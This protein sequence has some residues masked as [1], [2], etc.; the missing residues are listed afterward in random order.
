[1]TVATVAVPVSVKETMSARIVAWKD[2]YKGERCFCVGNGP[3]LKDTPLH[4]LENEYSFGLNKISDIYDKTP[5]RPSFYVNVTVLT[6]GAEWAQ[7]AK[8]SMVQTPSFID[9]G[10]LPYVLEAT[11]GEF[12]VP[13]HIFPI[14]VHKAYRQHDPD[15]SLWSH[16]ISERVSKFGS[17]MLTVLQI[18]VYMG[19]NPIYLLGCDLGWRPFGWG[20]ADPNHFSEDYWGLARV[21][22]EHKVIVSE[23]LA[24]RYTADARSSHVLA[25]KVCDPMGV[26]IYNATKGGDL[27][28]YPRVDFME[29]VVWS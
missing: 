16:D 15:P 18:A 11:D 3:S 26:K 14:V 8:K 22:E 20:E 2:K 17:S 6:T 28:V 19:F 12:F 5:W 7:A 23:G 1:M 4:L 9:Y 27:E 13:D 24:N 29:V 25:K 21:H 10:L